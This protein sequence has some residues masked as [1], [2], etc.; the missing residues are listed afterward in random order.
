MSQ[1][2][3][4]AVL[5]Q[6]AS[7]GHAGGVDA[8]GGRGHGPQGLVQ[9]RVARGGVGQTDRTRPEVGGGFTLA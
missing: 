2:Q 5:I 8:P 6:F 9:K 1:E 4:P 3:E 7:R